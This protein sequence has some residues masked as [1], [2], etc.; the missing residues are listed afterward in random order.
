MTPVV[1]LMTASTQEEGVRIARTLVEEE[2]AACCNVIGSVTS[3]YRWQ[4][5]VEE[6][7]EVQVLIKTFA[8]RFNALRQRVVEL[9]SYDVPELIALPITEGLP[10]YLDW[11]R[12]SVGNKKA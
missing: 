10:E 5:K 1:V 8:E 2:L 11:M 6:A 3:I 12:E 9:H 4:G 7:Q